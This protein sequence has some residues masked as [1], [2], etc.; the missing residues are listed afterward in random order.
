M[1]RLKLV[2]SPRCRVSMHLLTILPKLDVAK[3][4]EVKDVDGV[5]ERI[6][7][8]PCLVTKDDNIIPLVGEYNPRLFLEKES[9]HIKAW[10]QKI[11]DSHQ[12]I[13]KTVK[14]ELNSSK[15]NID[16]IKI[17]TDY[18]PI[19]EEDPLSISCEGCKLFPL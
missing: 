8:I 1:E 18:I 11:F 15:L 2:V 14:I 3:Y 6:G 5:S 7:Y 17:I 4:I 10:R 13:L 19:S 9:L 12:M 16:L